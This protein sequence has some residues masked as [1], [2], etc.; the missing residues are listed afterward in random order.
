M[1]RASALLSTLV[2]LAVPLVPLP[3]GAATTQDP[4]QPGDPLVNSEG[5]AYC[6]LNYVFDSATDGEVY[7]GTA[8]HCVDQGATVRTANHGSFGTVAFVGDEEDPSSD[9]ALIEVDDS[10]RKHVQAKVRGFPGA[11]TGVARPVDTMP[12]DRV[13]T[14]GWGTLTD[15]TETTRENRTGV[16][17]AHEVDLMQGET[18]AHPG[19]S[20][21]PWTHG[22]GLALGIV[23]RLTVG[24]DFESA[25][26]FVPIV[27]ETVTAPVP[28]PFA[29]DQG[30]TVQGLLAGAQNAGYDL[31]LRTAS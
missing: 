28:S 27:E 6:T 24:A 9:Y 1:R 25:E 7:M 5:E 3:T 14:S 29:G 4:I 2:L 10:A 18:T 16:L 19:D 31:S 30:P 26:V 11:P 13:M 20:G 17:T 22:S 21:G 12:G 15:G 23:S 8:A